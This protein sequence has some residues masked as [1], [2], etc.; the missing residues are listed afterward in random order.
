MRKDRFVF[1]TSYKGA[2]WEYKLENNIEIVC[3]GVDF[4]SVT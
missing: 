3:K 1:E 4:E 2:I